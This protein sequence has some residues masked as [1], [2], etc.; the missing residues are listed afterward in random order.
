[1]HPNLSCPRLDVVPVHQ[2]IERLEVAGLDILGPIRLDIQDVRTLARRQR[3]LERC[4]QRVLLEPGD[5]HGN[6]GMRL[7]EVARGKLAECDLRVLICLMR[8]DGQRHV[9]RI[10]RRS[11]RRHDGQQRDSKDAA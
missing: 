5:L 3:G 8:P 9:F 1:V 10:R 2:V 7:L 4:Q 11:W 6:A